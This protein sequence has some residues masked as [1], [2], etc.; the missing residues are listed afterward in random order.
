M[1]DDGKGPALPAPCRQCSD[2][3]SANRACSLTKIE[4]FIIIA[5]GKGVLMMGERGCRDLRATGWPSPQAGRMP[6]ARVHRS[7]EG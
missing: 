7:E 1:L 5:M 6:Y 2:L 3:I 4:R